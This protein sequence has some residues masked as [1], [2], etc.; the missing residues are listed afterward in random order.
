[1]TE[2]ASFPNLDELN[3]IPGANDKYRVAKDLFAGTIGG[4]AQ[5][6]SGQPF[7][8]V[9]VRMAS[10]TTGQ[11]KNT[12]DVVQKLIKNEG[13]LGFYKGTLTPLIG[14][15]A[16]VSIQFGVN[17]YMK[18]NVFN[19]SKHLTNAQY[20]MSGAAAGLANSVL[21]SPI[22]HVR[23][24]LQTQLTGNAG[25]LDII[26]RIYNTSGVSGIMKGLIPTALR[27]GQG[28]G[29]YFLTF[30]YLVKRNT[31]QNKIQRKDIPG[32]KLCLYGATAGYA[33]WMTVYPFD[34]VKSR[35]QTDSLT[36]PQ[37]KSIPDCVAK[38]YKANGIGGFFKGF[39]PTILRAAPANA[40]TFYAFELTMRLLG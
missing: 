28:M 13:V 20:Y 36:K 24:R 11:Y 40:A 23:I 21:A 4:V 26:K 31:I 7:D 5:V 6:L 2:E 34:I 25:P 10:D 39:T 30:E 38:I 16:C 37:I 33:M 1:M 32:W 22:E 8:T 17:E 18:R 19:G 35:L 3:H 27:E 29:M 14:V 12:L 9:K 15:G